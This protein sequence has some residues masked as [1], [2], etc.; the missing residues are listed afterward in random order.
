[1]VAGIRA[2]ALL[3]GVGGTSEL[4]QK[5]PC[6]IQI[7]STHPSPTW[8]WQQAL[9]SGSAGLALHSC[10]RSFLHA[11]LSSLAIQAVEMFLKL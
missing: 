3:G 2:T 8:S 10:D 7:T 9:G 6:M 5:F 4:R 11:S 1:M